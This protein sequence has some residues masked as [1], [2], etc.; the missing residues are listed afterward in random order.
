MSYVIKYSCVHCRST[1]LIIDT[2]HTLLLG[3]TRLIM[4]RC[5]F[6]RCSIWS[7]RSPSGVCKSGG[8]VVWNPLP[9]ISRGEMVQSGVFFGFHLEKNWT[10]PTGVSAKPNGFNDPQDSSPSLLYNN[11]DAPLALPWRFRPLPKS[12][13]VI[14]DLVPPNLWNPCQAPALAYFVAWIR[15]DFNPES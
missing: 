4:V 10:T 8:G 9:I 3:Y 5:I 15:R 12:V 13:G 1:N 6:V 7:Q 11:L 2:F 14:L